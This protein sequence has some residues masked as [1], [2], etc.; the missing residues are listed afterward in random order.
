MFF[1][2][3]KETGM[4]YSGF[5]YVLLWNL[6]LM[7]LMVKISRYG[8]PPDSIVFQNISQRVLRPK[9]TSR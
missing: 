3:C 8:N 6:S 2:E 1:V 4:I 5:V 7:A 9:D